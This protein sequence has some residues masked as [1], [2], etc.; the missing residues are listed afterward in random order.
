MIVI[1]AE[2][3][4][5]CYVYRDLSYYKAY[6]INVAQWGIMRIVGKSLIVIILKTNTVYLTKEE[7]IHN[8][9]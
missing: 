6:T 5:K 4:S 8:I 2:S 3:Y 9:V 1:L 7:M